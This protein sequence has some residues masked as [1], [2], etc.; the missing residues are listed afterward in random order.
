MFGE[1]FL[2][3]KK[4]KKT[5][6]NLVN[7]DTYY[8]FCSFFIYLLRYSILE[9]VFLLLS[10]I[11]LMVISIVKQGISNHIVYLI[12]GDHLLWFC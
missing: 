4:N 12:H 3:S 6:N 10:F 9:R 11:E 5:Q 7:L 1:S 2:K 8:S